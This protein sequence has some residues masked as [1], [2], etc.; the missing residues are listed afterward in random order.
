MQAL[1]G[2]VVG[3]HR[4]EPERQRM[5]AA[6]RRLGE[7]RGEFACAVIAEIDKEHRIIGLE[8][9]DGTVN[10]IR[11]HNGLDKF[12]GDAGGVGRTH[13]F[14]KVSRMRAFAVHELLPRFFNALP[15]LVAVHGVV[16]ANEAHE[17]SRF[18]GFRK[19]A[20]ERFHKSQTALGIGVAAVHESVNVDMLNAFTAGKVDEGQK[21]VKTRMYAAVGKESHQV[22][23][24]A[25]SFEVLKHRAA[26][27]LLKELILRTGAVDA[28]QILIDHA[29]G[30]D[31]EVADFGIAHLTF[32]QA[33]VFAV[34][35]KL[36]VRVP[37]G[38]T[39]NE[40]RVRRADGVGRVC[41]TAADAPA[42]ENHEKNFGHCLI[43][44][45]QRSGARLCRIKTGGAPK[46]LPVSIK[47]LR[48]GIE[49]QK[50]R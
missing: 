40:G 4:R 20:L 15:A 8:R 46:K 27:G 41:G 28:H 44:Q 23:R 47:D 50:A 42:V 29:A 18:T 3:R 10:L 43:T 37:G 35:A 38:K 11:F 7:N 45:M 24:L 34:G 1:K 22:K 39:F 2:C 49:L 6:L 19:L 32:G 26:F 12:V 17:L 33:Y 21:M 13:R 5:H 16:A 31:V 36:R 30:A 48:V 9:A 14:G 25:G